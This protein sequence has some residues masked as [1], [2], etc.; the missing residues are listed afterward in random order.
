MPTPCPG[1]CNNA[2]RKAEAALAATGTEH[3]IQPAW[4]QPTQCYLCVDRTIE[5]LEQLP[6]LLA[7]VR[8]EALEGTAAKLTGTIGRITMPTW[9]G[10]ASR[11]LIDRIVGEMAELQADILTQRGI[12]ADSRRPALGTAPNETAHI[13][14]IAAILLAHWD[15]AMQNHPAAGEPHDRDNANPGGQA[16]SWY[17][18]ALHFTK[19]DEQRD[20]QRLAPCP[21]CHGPYLVESRELR[22]VDGEPYIECRDPDCRRIMTRA[23]YDRYVKELN[24]SIVAAA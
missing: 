18:A 4:G 23:E 24:A 17:R 9:P 6:A 14:G 2:W 22:L 12:W 15:W 16:S 13:S 11:L 21:R 1:P 7:A 19:A 10:Q 5:Q 20:V 8:E 3:H